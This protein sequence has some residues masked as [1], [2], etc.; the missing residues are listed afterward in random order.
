MPRLLAFAHS[1][2]CGGSWSSRHEPQALRGLLHLHHL[3]RSRSGTPAP[4]EPAPSVLATL[5]EPI[6]TVLLCVRAQVS[7]RAPRLV[8]CAFG[9]LWAC[10]RSPP[11]PPPLPPP[12]LP[13]PPPPSQQ[14]RF[15]P[16]P[17]PRHAVRS[18]Q[19]PVTAIL[20]SVCRSARRHLRPGGPPS[21]PPPPPPKHALPQSPSPPPPSPLPPS[22][23][24]TLLP[25]APSA[26]AP[27]QPS[28]P[29]HR[30]DNAPAGAP[31]ETADTSEPRHC[32]HRP[33]LKRSAAI[34]PLAVRRRRRRGRPPP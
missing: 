2:M 21:Q 14:A 25:P 23:P 29:P 11:P 32:R 16:S 27:P 12:P 3:L 19:A 1:C 28:P 8:R 13:S 4:V 9:E 15:G 33:C 5:S 20:E 6:S 30:D 17:P 22:T 18:P 31:A 10:C 34:L 26:V 24:M 7:G